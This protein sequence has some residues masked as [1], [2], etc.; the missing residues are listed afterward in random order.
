[1]EAVLKEFSI[2]MDMVFASTSDSGSDVKRC[3]S[4]LIN[5]LWEWCIPHLAN[6]A[7]V[8]SFGICRDPNNSINNE[9]RNIIR[10]VK[11]TV[12]HVSKISIF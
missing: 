2:S 11:S 8:E 9:C 6:C 12:E 5:K 7:L 3:M 1:M 10:L 4:K